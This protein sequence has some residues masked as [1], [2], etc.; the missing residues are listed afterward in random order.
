MLSTII[1]E[2]RTLLPCRGKTGCLCING[3]GREIVS[4]AFVR[5]WFRSAFLLGANLDTK[6]SI[7]FSNPDF[8]QDIHSLD[9]FIRYKIGNSYEAY[10]EHK[11]F[12][13]TVFMFHNNILPCIIAS[14]TS[15]SLAFIVIPTDLTHNNPQ[16]YAY[17][18][19]DVE[20]IVDLLHVDAGL[21]GE[22]YD[23]DNQWFP[24]LPLPSINGA[25]VQDL[26]VFL[27]MPS[28]LPDSFLWC[29]EAS[30]IALPSDPFLPYQPSRPSGSLAAIAISTGLPHNNPPGCDSVFY[31][32]NN[33]G[34]IPQHNLS[35]VRS[36][37]VH[38]NLKYCNPYRDGDPQFSGFPP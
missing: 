26:S 35:V 36:P 19:F 33:F 23:H 7:L 38:K 32:I 15:D 8:L 34:V 17:A 9:S 37:E 28:V 14:S 4:N 21:D 2:S 30:H 5:D 12:A 29:V 18:G 3:L 22:Y 1:F 27:G 6:H 20:F 13:E 25:F 24:V 11:A 16:G 10:Y 31:D